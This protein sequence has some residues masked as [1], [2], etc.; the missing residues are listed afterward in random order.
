MVSGINRASARSLIVPDTPILRKRRGADDGRL[1]DALLGHDLVHAAVGGDVS[2]D[3]GFR[4]VGRVV[5][6]VR[7]DYVVLY[8]GRG[9]PAVDGE[10][11][12]AVVDGGE[13]GCVGNVS[14]AD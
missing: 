12:V 11:G 8:E 3:L 13:G 14:V 5:C 1:V 9:G 4:V 7:F 10:V 2:Q 6:A